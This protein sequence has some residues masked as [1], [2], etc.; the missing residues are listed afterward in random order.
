T[1]L[2]GVWKIQSSE[3]FG[4]KNEDPDYITYKIYSYPCFIW[5]AYHDKGKDFIGVAGGNYHYDGKKL[6]EYV[7]YWSYYDNIPFNL[8][9]NVTKLPSGSIQTISGNGEWKEILNKIK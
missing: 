3:W 6:V 9:I 7:E 1:S 2:E 8:E 4:K 5:G